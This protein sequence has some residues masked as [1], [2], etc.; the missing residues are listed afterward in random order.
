MASDD[1][2]QIFIKA[3]NQIN[4]GFKEFHPYL[5][6]KRLSQTE[7]KLLQAV[8]LL[9]KGKPDEAVESLEGLTPQSFFLRAY[10]QFLIGLAFNNLSQYDKSAKFLVNALSNFEASKYP[11]HAFKPISVLSRVYHNIKDC[12]RLEKYH[13]KFIEFKDNKN[14]SHCVLDLEYQIYIHQLKEEPKEALK[15]LEEIRNNYSD[16][17]Q[18]SLSTYLILEFTCYV[19]QGDYDRCFEILHEYKQVSGFK[20]RFNF[21]FMQSLLTYLTKEKASIY[22]YKKDYME[23]DYFFYQVKV[24]QNLNRHNYN[25]ALKFWKRLQDIIPSLYLDNF[26]YNG[27]KDLYALAFEK[28]HAEFQAKNTIDDS[29]ELN[30]EEL[31]GLKNAGD[32]LVYVLENQ[33]TY[34]DKYE[35]IQLVWEE[36]WSPKNDNRLRTLISRLKSKNKLNILNKDGKYKKVA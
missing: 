5:K 10:Q 6:D 27:P 1:S 8:Y 4:I 19:Q 21:F 28:A 15:C 25:Q 14:P 7:R 16:Q 36:D 35:L 2:T 29:T 3:Y 9:M 18:R 13:K 33:K 11:E 20:S 31:R 12:Q 34:I 30:L 22:A 32:K 23:G 24:I 17:I 26:K